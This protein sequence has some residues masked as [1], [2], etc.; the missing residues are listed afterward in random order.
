MTF[1][2]QQ[3]IAIAYV[4]TDML[5]KYNADR[6]M[7]PAPSADSQFNDAVCLNGAL[8]ELAKPQGFISL[9]AV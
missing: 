8:R 4:S 2:P 5:A 6:L 1:Y 7:C 9:A 3:A